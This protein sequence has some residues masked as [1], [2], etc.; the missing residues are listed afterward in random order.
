MAKFKGTSFNFGAN[1]R[2][3]PAKGK[4]KGSSGGGK[5]SNAW[6]GYTGGK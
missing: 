2:K 3:R 6:R 1:V 5:K 4:A